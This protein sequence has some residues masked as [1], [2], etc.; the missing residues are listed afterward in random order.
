MKRGKKAGNFCKLS[1]DG[2]GDGKLTFV[3]LLI[4]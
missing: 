3:C 1:A 2:L 4:V